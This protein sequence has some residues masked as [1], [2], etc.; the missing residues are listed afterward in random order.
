M[1]SVYMDRK[2]YHYSAAVPDGEPGGAIVFVHG[3][4]GNHRHWS[5]Q[6]P[7]LGRQMLALAVDL[8][9]HGLS[10]GRAAGSIREYADFIY[11][12][13]Q[14]VVGGPFF[15]AGHSMGGAIAMDF[16]LRFPDKLA[17]LVL[18]GTGARLRVA[19]ALL[20]TF[21]AGEHFLPLID[22]AYGPGTPA[23]LLEL[24][25]KEMQQLAP[26]VHYHDFLA[27]DNFDIMDRV[28]GIDVPTLVLAATEDRL[29][30]VKYGRFLAEQI[31]NARLEIIEKA[32]HMMMLEQP[33]TVNKLISDFT[34]NATTR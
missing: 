13:S 4:G 30:P 1:P 27:C 17:G 20:E 29:T 12:F 9:G 10:E 25:R 8:P 16:A 22:L 7:A 11:D 33:D 2:M 3:A 31:N 21:G 6:V 23:E 32:G 5:F 19:P 18:V 24:A 28:S 26:E 34:N 15:L 14:H